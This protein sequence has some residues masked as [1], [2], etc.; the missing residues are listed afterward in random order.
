MCYTHSIVYVIR[1]FWLVRVRRARKYQTLT[2]RD[3]VAAGLCM[4]VPYLAMKRHTHTPTHGQW[5]TSWERVQ[6]LSLWVQSK[7]ADPLVWVAAIDF[8]SHLLT[9]GPGKHFHDNAVLINGGESYLNLQSVHVVKLI[10]SRFL[11]M[12]IKMTASGRW[13]GLTEMSRNP[14]Q[15][16]CSRGE[17]ADVEN[18]NTYF[19]QERKTICHWYPGICRS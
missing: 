7:S 13:Y 14:D 8:S 15:H 11:C 1:N 5:N 2:L 17:L 6:T 9:F 10:L 16:F 18:I 19:F 4:F 12:F 3:A